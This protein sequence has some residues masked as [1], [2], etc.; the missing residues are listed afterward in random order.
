MIDIPLTYITN[1]LTILG[2]LVEI[3]GIVM[4]ANRFLDVDIVS[5]LFGLVSA[6][7]RSKTAQMI[8]KVSMGEP[9]NVFKTFRGLSLIAWG[10]SLQ[11]VSFVTILFLGPQP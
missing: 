6:P 1:S 7:F 10:F 8:P 4:M 5:L 2:Y 3:T 9:E 11:F